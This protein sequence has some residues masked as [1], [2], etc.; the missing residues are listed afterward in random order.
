[1][2]EIIE[3]MTNRQDPMA[4]LM[5]KFNAEETSQ[6]MIYH[7]RL[8]A[9]SWLKGNLSEFAPYIVGDVNSYCEEWILPV[10][11]EIDHLGL[12]LLIGVLLKPANMV[13]EIAYLDR[14]EG[15]NVNVHRM[16]DDA[17]SQDPAVLARMIHLLYRPGHYDLLYRIPPPPQPIRTTSLQ[18]NRVSSFSQRH[19]IQSAGPSLQDFATVDLSPLSMIPG[20][21]PAG[22][23]PI[24]SP[25]ATAS[26]IGDGYSPSPQSPWM[27]QPFADGLP[28]ATPSRP[29][30]APASVLAPV[31]TEVSLRF[32]KY[33][34]PQLPGMV[35][36]GTFAPEPAF[37][38]STFKNSH[39]N[40][41]HYNNPHFQPEEYRP[42]YDDEFPLVK[43]GGRKRSTEH[44]GI[45][46]KGM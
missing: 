32:S 27:P 25:P 10:N 5:Q 42:E 21:E 31:T 24:A 37:T 40:T 28:Q 43:T 39:Y 16:P 18:V 13:L 34:F 22:I 8:M 35:D 26:P 3:A 29:S 12:M 19:E 33:N 44:C 17:N 9:A 30:P 36:A 41:A 14:S 4:I 46:K 1:M 11:R 23:S 20:Y 2:N 45:T 7:L 38:T 15:D 6:P